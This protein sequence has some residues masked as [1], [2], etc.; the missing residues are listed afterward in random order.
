MIHAIFQPGGSG[1]VQYAFRLV[2]VN[3]AFRILVFPVSFVSI[4]SG[5]TRTFAGDPVDSSASGSVADWSRGGDLGNFEAVTFRPG[6]V[7]LL[8]EMPGSGAGSSFFRSRFL[9]G[10]T[11]TE[12]HP[13]PDLS[14]PDVQPVTTQDRF[15]RGGSM[16]AVLAL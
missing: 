8:G 13:G 11:A 10:S 14:K 5:K 2:G 6:S 3:L 4:S 16:V 12:H 7:I 1:T 9:A 15:A